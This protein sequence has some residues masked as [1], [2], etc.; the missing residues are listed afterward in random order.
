ML[1]F[2]EATIFWSE[3]SIGH[4]KTVLTLW[5]LVFAHS[6]LFIC[7]SCP[8]HDTYSSLSPD[9]ISENSKI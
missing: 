3:L 9:V 6:Y 5:Y 8:R 7:F 2:R 4:N 1:L